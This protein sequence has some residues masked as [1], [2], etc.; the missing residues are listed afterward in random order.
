MY[1]HMPRGGRWNLVKWRCHVLRCAPQAR[2]RPTGN[3]MPSTVW[4]QGGDI[5][6][7][8]HLPSLQY[9][10]TCPVLGLN[11]VWNQTPVTFL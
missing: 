2:A 11:V 7:G 1:V 9:C 10:P 4:G 5:N 3:I 8:V 6:L